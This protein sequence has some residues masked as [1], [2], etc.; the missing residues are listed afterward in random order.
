[1]FDRASGEGRG[2]GVYNNDGGT[3]TLTGVMVM[4]NMPDNCVG[5]ITGC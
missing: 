1:M 5:T 4:F 2:G 3:A